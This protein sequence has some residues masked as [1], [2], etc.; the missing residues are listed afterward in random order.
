[1]KNENQAGNYL[2]GDLYQVYELRKTPK[3]GEK[4]VAIMGLEGGRADGKTLG[5]RLLGTKA[6]DNL[7]NANEVERSGVLVDGN[8]I[9]LDT[10]DILNMLKYVDRL[11]THIESG[12]M[13]KGEDELANALS[14]V[15]VRQ[16]TREGDICPMAA[17]YAQRVAQA[18]P[19]LINPS[20]L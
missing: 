3:W 17:D 14:L 1:M 20:L 7:H 4:L 11:V 13:S 16:I 10:S 2:L 19:D 6:L 12:S 18:R 8:T 9:E 15:V 5:E